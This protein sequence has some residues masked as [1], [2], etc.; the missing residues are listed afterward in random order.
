M[1]KLFIFLGTIIFELHLCGSRAIHRVEQA[2][3][4]PVRCGL[5]LSQV[6][7]DNDACLLTLRRFK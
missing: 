6:S 4:D 7:D 3:M 1:K 5:R 2:T